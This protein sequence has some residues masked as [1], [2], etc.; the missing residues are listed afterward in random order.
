MASKNIIANLNKGD[1]KLNGE[2]YHVWHL[3]I[4]YVLEK[5]EALEVVNHT[6]EDPG[7]GNGVQQRWDQEIYRA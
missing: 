3:K 6:M 2:N 4:Q 1:K 7:Q 5:Q